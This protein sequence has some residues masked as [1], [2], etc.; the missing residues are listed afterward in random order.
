MSEICTVCLPSGPPYLDIGKQSSPPHPSPCRFRRRGTVDCRRRVGI[1]DAR[2]PS[3]LHL[4][5][6]LYLP[7]GVDRLGAAL[8]ARGPLAV[9][10]ACSEGD[11]VKDIVSL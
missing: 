11:R 7:A 1:G 5:G 3:R 2:A 9:G 10:A 8:L 4:V 6:D